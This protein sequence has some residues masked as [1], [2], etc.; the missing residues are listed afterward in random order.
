MTEISSK[1]VHK[2]KNCKVDVAQI[3]RR[4]VRQKHSKPIVEKFLKWVDESPFFGKNAIRSNGLIEKYSSHMPPIAI[5]PKKS[6]D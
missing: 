1:M 4:K 2:F 6:W 3:K 5:Y